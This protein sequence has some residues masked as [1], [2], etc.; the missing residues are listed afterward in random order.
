MR[1]YLGTAFRFL[2]SSKTVILVP[3]KDLEFDF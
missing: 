3:E 1:M 2:V